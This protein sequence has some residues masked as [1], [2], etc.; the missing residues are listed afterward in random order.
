MAGRRCRSCL[1]WFRCRIAIT[2]QCRSYRKFRSVSYA[3]VRYL[4]VLVPANST[5]PA[6]A[7]FSAMANDT[8]HQRSF[9][10]DDAAGHGGCSCLQ[11]VPWQSDGLNMASYHRHCHAVLYVKMKTRHSAIF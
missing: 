6:D 7:A 3:A 4:T 5:L 1:C 10:L 2:K 11:F 9:R 8:S